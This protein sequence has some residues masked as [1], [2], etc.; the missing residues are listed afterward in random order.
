MYETKYHYVQSM[1]LCH[2]P[3]L[4]YCVCW[5]PKVRAEA[6]IAIAINNQV[7]TNSRQSQAY[8]K[9]SIMEFLLFRIQV[10]P[11]IVSQAMM[12]EWTH[13]VLLQIISLHHISARY[14]N[15]HAIDIRCYFEMI[16]KTLPSPN[17]LWFQELNNCQ[18]WKAPNGIFTRPYSRQN[19]KGPWLEFCFG[20]LPLSSFML[21]ELFSQYEKQGQVV[22]FQRLSK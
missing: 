13:F 14:C 7:Q 22:G 11:P 6:L 8:A 16:L 21:Q 15:L 10:S 4:N 17:F 18:D 20:R 3:P 1:L 12:K 19:L 9:T 5:V 2:L